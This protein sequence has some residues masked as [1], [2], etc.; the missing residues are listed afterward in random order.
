V[1]LLVIA[2]LF[3]GGAVYE[4]FALET[5]AVP[6]ITELTKTRL[7]AAA[8]LTFIGAAILHFLEERGR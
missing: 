5:K 8:V 3:I 6:T 7:G 1:R 2:T 4:F